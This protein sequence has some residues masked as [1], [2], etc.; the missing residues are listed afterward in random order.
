[1]DSSFQI[2]QF[3]PS[4]FSFNN[5]LSFYLQKFLFLIPPSKWIQNELV[6]VPSP[7]Q[8]F[9]YAFYFLSFSFYFWRFA[10]W[11]QKIIS[12]PARCSISGIVAEPHRILAKSFSSVHSRATSDR[13][14]HFFDFC[15]LFF[16]W[17]RKTA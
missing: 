3:S 5:L 1:M 13:Q 2:D 17:I 16:G 11:C 14:V 12:I 10:Q 8:S 4:F 15:A 9:Y 7:K 6:L